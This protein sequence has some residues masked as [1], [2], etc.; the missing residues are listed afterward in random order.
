MDTSF[1][2]SPGIAKKIFRMLT[3]IRQHEILYAEYQ[4]IK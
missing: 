3:E 2:L 4:V 1:P